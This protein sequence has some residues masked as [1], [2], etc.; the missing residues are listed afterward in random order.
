MTILKAMLLSMCLLFYVP[1]FAG[2]IAKITSKNGKVIL[3]NGKKISGELHFFYRSDLLKIKVSAS[4]SKALTP[5]QVDSFTFYDKNFKS[6]RTF[7]SVPKGFS[8]TPH[9]GF[10]EVISSGEF[11]VIGKLVYENKA[12]K[13]IYRNPR[14]KSHKV[15][16]PRLITHD[17]FVFYPNKLIPLEQLLTTL[18][19]KDEETASFI[20]SKKLKLNHIQDQLKIIAFYNEKLANKNFYIQEFL[21]KH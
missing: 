19:K 14:L 6:D 9:H 5:H 20:E 21:V 12:Y 16:V 1:T 11:K 8:H 3:K 18:C 13:S 7:I 17:F 10:F 2:S 4:L 15:F